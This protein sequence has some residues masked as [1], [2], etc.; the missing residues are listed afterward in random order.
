MTN[1]NT[2]AMTNIFREHLQGPISE[3]F[4]H[5]TYDQN[6]RENMT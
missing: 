6:D 5:E 3:T 4:N 2:K 1:T